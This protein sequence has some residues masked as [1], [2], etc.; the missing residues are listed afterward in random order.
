[1]LTIPFKVHSN[2]IYF[3]ESYAKKHKYKLGQ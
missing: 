3:N 2:T 1:M